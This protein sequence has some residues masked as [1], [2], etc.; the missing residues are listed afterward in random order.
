MILLYDVSIDSIHV[1]IY[2]LWG[3]WINDEDRLD[4]EYFP[5]K[6]HVVDGLEIVCS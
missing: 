4:F 2:E 6:G 1:L 5:D 3:L